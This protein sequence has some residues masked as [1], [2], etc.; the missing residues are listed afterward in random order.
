VSP[1]AAATLALLAAA[2][3][4]PQETAQS[5]PMVFATSVQS[6]FIDAFVSHDGR[7][8]PGLRASDFV[9]KE[10]GTNRS[11]DFLPTS[12]LPIRAIL[13][14][15][16]SGSMKGDKLAR[17]RSAGLSFLDRLRPQDEAALVSFSDEIAW[18]S[19]LTS[20]FARVRQGLM[21][22]E[23]R[24]AT[25][26]YD[27]LL[28]A[29]LVPQSALRTLVVL[30][31]DGED[32]TSWLGETQIKAAVQRSNSLLYVI[33]ARDPKPRPN[34]F[35]TSTSGDELKTLREVAEITG[36]SLM[37]ITSADQIGAAFSQIVD[38][39]KSRYVLRYTPDSEPT[40]GWHKLELKL[41][42]RKGNV[43][44]RTGY[45]VEPP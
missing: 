25:S 41:S 1:S 38:R 18:R 15:D 40:A 34:P 9:L 28:A 30:F 13:A 21:A 17:L 4:A 37:E 23:A 42:S 8:V 29:L 33:A 31:S 3:G 10:N 26:V 19:P 35:R 14:F 45:W 16:V 24:G 12:E 27:G 20:D 22:L 11:F 39:M 43:R 5:Q 44:G 32:T 2:A 6:V 36:G 7:T